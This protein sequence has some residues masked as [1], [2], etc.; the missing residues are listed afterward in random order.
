MAIAKGGKFLAQI[1]K[2]ADT[3]LDEHERAR[4]VRSENTAE[5]EA[6]LDRLSGLR[7][8]STGKNSG[9]DRHINNNENQDETANCQ[10]FSL[11]P[12][13]PLSLSLSLSLSLLAALYIPAHM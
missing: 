13:L 8:P 5:R 3:R 6:L 10:Y 2:D 7:K 4:R 9:S 1:V 12:S 11:S